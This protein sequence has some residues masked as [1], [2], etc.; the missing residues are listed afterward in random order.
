VSLVSAAVHLDVF[1]SEIQS[2]RSAI[3]RKEHVAEWM[4]ELKHVTVEGLQALEDQLT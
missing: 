1:F 3:D 4:K 2:F